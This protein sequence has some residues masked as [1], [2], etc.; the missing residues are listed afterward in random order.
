MRAEGLSGAVRGKKIS[1][2]VP[3]HQVVRALGLVDR[4]FVAPAPDRHRVADFTH[5]AAR[6]VAVHIAFVVETL[7][8]HIGGRSAALTEQTELVLS[9]M[10]MALWQRDRAG[11]P[12]PPAGWCITRPP[13]AGS[14]LSPWPPTS[15]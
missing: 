8:R 13:E 4:A 10:E 7:S 3:D 6:A 5:V 11:S 1:T 15:P 9:P 12:I 2:T 14:P